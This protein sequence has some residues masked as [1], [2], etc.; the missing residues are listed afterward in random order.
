MLGK[1]FSCNKSVNCAV[2]FPDCHQLKLAPALKT[3][4]QRFINISATSFAESTI[5][6]YSPS[7]PPHPR[8]S[9][10]GPCS[11]QSEL[12]FPP[13]QSD[14]QV[15]PLS[16]INHNIN[17]KIVWL[18]VASLEARFCPMYCRA[19]PT[20][21]DSVLLGDLQLL[22]FPHDGVGLGWVGLMILLLFANYSAR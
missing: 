22:C 17:N 6:I 13:S 8:P 14:L 5:V 9:S 19:V 21:G 2:W 4:G 3:A 20:C 11:S 18:I 15:V 7:H 10:P 16:R 1:D 12:P